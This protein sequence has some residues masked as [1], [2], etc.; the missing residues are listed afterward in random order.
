[1]RE[2]KLYYFFFLQGG[3]SLIA[4]LDLGKMAW[5]EPHIWRFTMLVVAIVNASLFYFEIKPSIHLLWMFLALSAALLTYGVWCGCSYDRYYQ[6]I[7][8]M[9]HPLASI[10]F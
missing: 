10:G 1:V 6:T 2:L 7:E 9:A 5:V 3:S 8:I 4:G